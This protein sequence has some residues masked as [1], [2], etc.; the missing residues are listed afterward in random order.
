MQLLKDGHR[1]SFGGLKKTENTCVWR[2]QETSKL[3][4]LSERGLKNGREFDRSGW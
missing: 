1:R 2:N 3:K 4:A